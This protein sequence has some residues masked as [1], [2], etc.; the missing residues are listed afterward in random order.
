MDKTSRRTRHAR[1]SLRAR[2]EMARL[3]NT[4]RA[5]LGGDLQIGTGR[6]T[7]RVYEAVKVIGKTS[8]DTED[9][10][11][12][13]LEKYAG[14]TLASKERASC[15]YLW[16]RLCPG[17][18]GEGDGRGGSCRHAHIRAAFSLLFTTEISLEIAINLGKVTEHEGKT[19]DEMYSTGA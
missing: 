9:A 10:I 6:D 13:S 12:I 15:R 5:L 4:R 7:N 18:G 8:I 1:E 19:P 11:Q 16:K 3:S 17:R 2:G 14:C